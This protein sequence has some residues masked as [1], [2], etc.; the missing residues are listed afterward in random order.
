MEPVIETE[1]LTKRYGSSRGI[2]EISISVDRGEVFGFPGP[3]RRRQDDD[4]PDVVD[5]LHPTSGGATIFGLTVVVEDGRSEPGLATLRQLRSS[6]ASLG[7]GV[8]EA[9]ALRF[10]GVATQADV[11]VCRVRQL[12]RRIRLASCQA[13]RLMA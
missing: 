6:Q 11:R 10:A 7:L 13:A 3:K 1:R 5:F 4:A 2:E 9:V 12:L 8:V